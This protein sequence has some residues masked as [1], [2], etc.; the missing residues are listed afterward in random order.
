MKKLYLASLYAVMALFLPACNDDVFIK[1]LVVS[2]ENVE[3]GPENKSG[4]ID[5]SGKDWLVKDVW[6]DGDEGYSYVSPSGDGSYHVETVYTDLYVRQ[7]SDCI[8]IELVNYCGNSPA[9]LG[10]VVTDGYEY[11]DVTVSVLPTDPFV[12]EIEDISYQFTSWSGYPDEDFTDNVITYTYP[13]GLSEPVSFTFPD[14][15]DLP[16]LYRFEP[17]PDAD[18][19][20]R[21]V[22]SS[23]IV[24]PV[25]SYTRYTPPHDFWSLTGREAPLTTQRSMM[26]TTFVPP[27]PAAVDL[28]AGQPLAVS[29]LC[30]YESVGLAC[31]IKA[32]N[33]ASGI[34]ETIECELRLIHPVELSTKVVVKQ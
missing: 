29:L 21:R 25:P 20:A 23:G 24:V 12:I 33:P 32:K 9:T 31:T 2:T 26:K 17:R 15:G 27:M 5:V 4:R 3:V 1:P 14:L 13:E 10:F 19:F 18:L 6:F 16:E 11:E 30:E 22:L 28:P 8:G 7:Y 34:S